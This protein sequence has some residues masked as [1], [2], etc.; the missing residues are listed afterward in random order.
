M[1]RGLGVTWV[2]LVPE[3]WGVTV[4]EGWG[5]SVVEDWGVTVAEERGV[6]AEFC[7]LS[8]EQVQVLHFK[9]LGT[10]MQRIF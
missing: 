9:T 4:A 2:D 6:M 8:L 5:A 7:T 3:D 10:T 1:P